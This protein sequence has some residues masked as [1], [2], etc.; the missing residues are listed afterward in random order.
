MSYFNSQDLCLVIKFY[1]K[2]YLIIV[3]SKEYS[4]DNA[5][6]SVYESEEDG[7]RH[8]ERHESSEV[9]SP[10]KEE[11]VVRKLFHFLFQIIKC[12]IKIY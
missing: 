12:Y 4:S 5:S 7:E 6:D 11:L 8:G 1:A 2:C 3:H 9:G 10:G